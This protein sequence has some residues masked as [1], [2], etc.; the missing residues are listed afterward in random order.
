MDSII[1]ISGNIGCGKT[2]IIDNLTHFY[3]D[4]DFFKIFKEP[5]DSWGSWLDLFY[6]NPNKY[7]F[8]FQM[9]VLIDFLYLNNISDKDFIITERSPLDSLHVFTKT[10]KNDDK[11]TYLEYNLYQ[12][13]VKKIGWK[14]KHIIY[15]QTDPNNC[16]QRIKTRMRGCESGIDESYIQ[17]IH[18]IYEQWIDSIKNDHESNINVHIINGN[19]EKETV[20][21][22]VKEIISKI[23]E[24]M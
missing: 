12:E 1:T 17:S 14:P 22:N 10:L 6:T 9:K 2:T 18:A 4:K 11:I 8:P 23:K 21:E 24:N 16:I 19:Q 20:F 13:Y 15:I 5:I 3:K 7:A